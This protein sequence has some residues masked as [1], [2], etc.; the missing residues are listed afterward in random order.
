[1]SE[2]AKN[3][4]KV[5]F[6]V[7]LISIILVYPLLLP[8]LIIK[9]VFFDDGNKSSI[10]KSTG[11]AIIILSYFLCILL[12]PLLFS[13]IPFIFPLLLL[14][15]FIFIPLF[16]I[17]DYFF[18]DKNKKNPTNSISDEDK[19][20][21]Y[22]KPKKRSVIS[23]LV[24]CVLLVLAI[25][26]VHFAHSIGTWK[27][28][29]TTPRCD[30]YDDPSLGTE[31]CTA[32]YW[33]RGSLSHYLHDEYVPF[34]VKDEHIRE[35]KSP[36]G[37]DINEDLWSKNSEN[38]IFETLASVKETANTWYKVCIDPA[39]DRYECTF[40]PRTSWKT[41]LLN[42]ILGFVFVFS[43]LYYI[44][45]RD[46]KYARNSVAAMIDIEKMATEHKFDDET[47]KKLISVAP[48]ILKNMSADNRVYFD[49]IMDGSVSVNDKKFGET[50][51]QGNILQRF[52]TFIND[53]KFLKAVVMIMAGHLQSHPEDL[54]RV[55][56]I[57]DNEKSMPSDLANVV[58]K[59][60]AK[61]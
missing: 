20:K 61:A 53:K 27:A 14:L 3:I 21:K 36:Q 5:I 25:F 17:H 33:Y 46:R 12:F 26:I 58:K 51:V 11:K 39:P 2:H 44:R 40:D 38:S 34:Y 59:L 9:N 1:M 16:L 18:D 13:F 48:H 31:N 50:S 22:A 6:E 60:T 57:F 35:V 4:G 54:Q 23:I 42:L 43:L 7:I 41:Q 24:E 29:T 28:L 30:E 49:M 19:Y 55:K 37:V 15:P 45:K 32:G 52:R 8:V 47:K 10:I 56:E